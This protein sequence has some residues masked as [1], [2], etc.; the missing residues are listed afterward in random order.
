[1]CGIMAFA[2]LIGLR[3]LSAGVQEASS[4]DPMPDASPA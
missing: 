3:G 1:M 4:E 2:G